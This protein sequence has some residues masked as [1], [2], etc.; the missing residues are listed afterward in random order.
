MC[1]KSLRLF[2]KV[3]LWTLLLS[4]TAHAGN[5]NGSLTTKVQADN[6]ISNETSYSSEIWGTYEYRGANNNWRIA[7]DFLLR[8]S[9]LDSKTD[10]LAEFGIGYESG[11]KTYQA[12]IEKTFSFMDTTIKAGRF[13]RSDNLG[14]YLL[15]G[16]EIYYQSKN[17]GLA[18]RLYGGKP[19]RIDHLKTEKADLL[20]GADVM[21]HYTPRWEGNNWLPLALDVIDLRL[22]FQ[23]FNN[24]TD[25][26]LLIDADDSVKLIDQTRLSVGFN[27]EGRILNWLSDKFEIRLLATY[28]LDKHFFENML[29]ETQLDVNKNLRLRYSY[30]LY[31]P[32]RIS[33]PSFRERFYNYTNLGHQA[34]SRARFDYRLFEA[35]TI[36]L[37]GLHSNREIGGTGNG[38]NAALKIKPW[39]GNTTTVSADFLEL[40]D[41]SLYTLGFR[42]KQAIT[43]KLSLEVEAIIRKEDKLL[44]GDNNVLGGE[45]KVDY[46]LKNNLVLSLD[47]NY[48]R[49]SNFGDEH[50]GRFQVTYYFD[51]FKPKGQ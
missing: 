28:R 48:I 4:A 3:I 47:T 34:L 50:L 44:Y 20:Y 24:T 10:D 2:V 40:G 13:Q 41:E 42:F 6:R 14:F 8:G 19:S 31:D 45:I 15:D 11:Y 1:I 35:L 49:N 25:I 32:N 7:Y 18:F 26:G 12:F 30:E 9:D 38:V 27:T 33:Y 29:F 37:G 36:S 5:W 21:F 16:A 17:K 23:Q 51:N 46:M 43:S 39:S 22:G